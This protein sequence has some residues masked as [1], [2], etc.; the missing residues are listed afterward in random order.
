MEPGS[1][2]SLQSHESAIVEALVA[3]GYTHRQ[4]SSIAGPHLAA[5]HASQLDAFG[6]NAPSQLDITTVKYDDGWS[7]A[8][9]AVSGETWT[10]QDPCVIEGIAD[11][12]PSP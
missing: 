12:A 2:Y 4:A 10:L 1:R 7:T 3:L 5:A 6:C 11:Q 9:E 8:F